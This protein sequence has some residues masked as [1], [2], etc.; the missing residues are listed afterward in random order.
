MNGTPCQR[1]LSMSTCTSAR[2]SVFRDGVHALFLGVVR[3]LPAVDGPGGVPGPAGVLGVGGL[4]AAGPQEGGD[5][6]AE[7]PLVHGGGRFDR[8]QRHDLQQVALD[9][10]AE[11][12][13]AVVVAGPALQ[14]EV[15]VEDD[16]HL[17]DVLP[18][19][20]RLQEGVRE[21]QAQD[22]QHRGLAQEVV[23]PVDVVLGDQRGQGP[24]EV[25][26]G[27]L[28]GAERLLHHQPGPGGN[29]LR[30]QGLAGQLAD[31]RRQGEVDGHG[32]FQRGQ[33]P[34]QLP[35]GGDVQPVVAGGFADPLQLAACRWCWPASWRR[36]RRS[37]GVPATVPGSSRIRAR[38]HQGEARRRGPSPPAGPVPAA[39][40]CR[41]G[42]PRRRG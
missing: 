27:F 7:V 20:D 2:V 32:S 6:V 24:V 1:Q 39:A 18:V 4:D 9:H 16:L 15:L 21:A 23:H 38:T 8:H 26:G 36:R 31:L 29:L 41:S 34:G 25:P 19:P 14:R 42:R 33:Q 40:A 12:A 17:L 22:V 35:L 5:G 10:V 11:G 28:A 37:P 13:G 30:G 3:D